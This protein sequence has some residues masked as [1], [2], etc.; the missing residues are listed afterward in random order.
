LVII[1]PN[2]NFDFPS[3]KITVDIN[4]VRPTKKFPV[5]TYRPSVVDRGDPIAWNT[6]FQ[7]LFYYQGP[8]MV[9]IDELYAAEVIF[10]SKRLPGGNF[11]NAYLTQ[12]RARGK[13][14]IAAAQ[15]PYN[16][17]KNI[18]EQAEWFYMFDLPGPE[19]RDLMA[20]VM[21]RYGEG[22]KGLVDIR[23]RNSLKRYEFWFKGPDNENALRMKVR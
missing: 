20:Q 6:L 13:G 12:G 1:D 15:R 21:G 9:Y 23:E 3:N 18:I 22:P 11:L 8:L 17:P 2:Y 5:V 14:L 16:I 19:S 10:G 7:T 4:E